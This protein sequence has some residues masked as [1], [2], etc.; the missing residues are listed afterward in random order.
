MP[1]PRPQEARGREATG[2]GGAAPVSSAVRV[3][4]AKVLGVRLRTLPSHGVFSART[5]GPETAP[6]AAMNPPVAQEEW[7]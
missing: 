1:G 5:H 4:R 7:C 3:T 2:S 6:S